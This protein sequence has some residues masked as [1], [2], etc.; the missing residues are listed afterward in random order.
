MLRELARSV[1]NISSVSKGQVDVG[2]KEDGVENGEYAGRDHHV[3]EHFWRVEVE[4][5]YDGPPVVQRHA[6][7]DEEE[8]TAHSGERVQLQQE[9]TIIVLGRGLHN[10]RT[11]DLHIS[12]S[13]ECFFLY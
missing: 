7:G 13:S 6:A 8:H 1:D 9:N 2:E 3:H 5:V 4:A 12:C 11:K 10:Y